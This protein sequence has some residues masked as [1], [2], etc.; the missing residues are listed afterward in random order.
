MKTRQ[1][2]SPTEWQA[3]LKA[4]KESQ[5]SIADFCRQQELDA[6]YFS[7]R[8][9]A[10]ETQETT[11]APNRFIKMSPAPSSPLMPVGLLT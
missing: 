8:K 1:H 9:H 5:L 10:F 3:L 7:K 4:Q 6:K 11:L 2:R